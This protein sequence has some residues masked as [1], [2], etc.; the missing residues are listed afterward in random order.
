[1]RINS[2]EN[3]ALILVVALLLLAAPLTILQA[4]I[5]GDVLLTGKAVKIIAG[6]VLAVM[7]IARASSQFSLSAALLFFISGLFF[8]YNALIIIG[9]SSPD[10]GV[11]K[12]LGA[13]FYNYSLLLVVLPYFWLAQFPA[14]GYSKGA[15][16]FIV[17]LTM[18]GVVLAQLF[19]LMQFLLNG[20]IYPQEVLKL[21]TD[22]DYIKF[23]H[24]GGLVRVGSVFKSPLEFGFICVLVSGIAYAILLSKRRDAYIWG[25]FLLSSL[26]VFI[27][28]S[29]TAILMYICNGLLITSYFLWTNRFQKVSIKA[30][31]RMNISIL[32]LA[33]LAMAVVSTSKFFGTTMDAT[34]L[35]IRIENWGGLLEKLGGTSIEMLFGLG[36]VQNGAYGDYHSV[37]ID[38]TYLGV[39][40]TG[41][42]VGFVF[43]CIFLL[44]AITLAWK[45][46]QSVRAEDRLL[47]VSFIAFFVAFLIGGLTENLMHIMFYPFVCLLMLKL[48]PQSE[49]KTM[50]HK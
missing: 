22:G 44:M 4:F 17:R 30:V 8:L 10:V 34:N 6:L 18:I 26:C 25:L 50:R 29:R 40:L 5:F 7:L 35:L 27:T 36:M 49:G 3:G 2:F 39:M 13:F 19:G 15:S 24:I 33:V 46:V 9:S 21:L 31:I 12:A 48:L 11:L 47:S 45:Y 14:D 16:E 20:Y 41:G 1:M 32:V 37:I 38:N 42:L 23:D 28:I 43:V